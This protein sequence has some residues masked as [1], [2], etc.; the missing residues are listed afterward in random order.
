MRQR[1]IWYLAVGLATAGWVSL[2]SWLER[3]LNCYIDNCAPYAVMWWF[4]LSAIL[5][6]A[7]ITITRKMGRISLRSLGALAASFTVSGVLALTSW[8]YALDPA[9]R[10]EAALG[11]LYLPL[12]GVPVVFAVVLVVSVVVQRLWPR[13]SGPS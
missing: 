5:L 3:D 11:A 9:D 7:T 10:S 13:Q 8:S 1:W 6:V 4:G 12:I 2:M